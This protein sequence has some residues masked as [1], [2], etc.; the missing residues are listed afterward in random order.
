[1]QILR[2]AYAKIFISRVL[3]RCVYIHTYIYSLYFTRCK[4]QRAAAYNFFRCFAYI[5]RHDRKS[6]FEEKKNGRRSAKKE[7]KAII[8]LQKS[9][10]REKMKVVLGKRGGEATKRRRLWHSRATARVS[11]EKTG[12]N[13]ALCAT[14]NVN[15]ERSSERRSLFVRSP[16]INPNSRLPPCVLH[17]NPPLLNGGTIHCA[18]GTTSR[19]N[20]CAASRLAFSKLFGNLGPSILHIRIW[21][22]ARAKGREECSAIT[23]RPRI[24]RVLEG[25]IERLFERKK[26]E[27]EGRE[28]VFGE[29]KG[30]FFS[31]LRLS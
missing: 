10:Q 8:D 14:I 12:Q 6:I 28:K 3:S 27:E 20:C 9:A 23:R 29:R 2:I 24:L 26:G 17:S 30:P 13:S 1:M 5:S 18:L 22:L 19:F 15:P 11:S 31:F 21:R 4:I 25:T 7:G 16:R